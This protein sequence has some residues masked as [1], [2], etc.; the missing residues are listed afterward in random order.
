MNEREAFLQRADVKAAV[1]ELAKVCFEQIGQVEGEAEFPEPAAF[2][3]GKGIDPPEG[4]T[5]TLH[6]AV[7]EDG[8]QPESFDCGDGTKSH[9]ECE[10][11]NGKLRCVWVC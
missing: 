2:L 7:H 3:R 8:V 6:H 5:L 1:S 11:V 4:T 10:M 9:P